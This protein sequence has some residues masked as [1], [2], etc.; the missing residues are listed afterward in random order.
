MEDSIKIALDS[1]TPVNVEASA[2]LRESFRAQRLVKEGDDVLQLHHMLWYTW[3]CLSVPKFQIVAG[4]D[5]D[6]SAFNEDVTMG[7]Q[8]PAWDHADNDSSGTMELTTSPAPVESTASQIRHPFSETAWNPDI[9]D[10]PPPDLRA[11]GL[12]KRDLKFSRQESSPGSLKC[13]VS[14]CER[15]CNRKGLLDHL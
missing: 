12:K 8:E 14:F 7:D 2:S 9:T 3:L 11:K 6:W 5:A 4:L 15:Q 10:A 13:P 1:P